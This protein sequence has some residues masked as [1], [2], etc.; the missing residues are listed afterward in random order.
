[1]QRLGRKVSPLG[2]TMDDWRIAGE[3]AVRLGD[4]FDLEFVDEVTDEIAKVAP[5]HL[6]A[7]APLLR[8]A[9][10][11]VVLPVRAHLDEI[12]L[13]TRELNIMSEDGQA[14]SWDPIR[15]EAAAP[16]GS[17]AAVE[18]SGAGG[19]VNITPDAGDP[20]DSPEEAAAALDDAH[21]VSATA[22]RDAPALHVWD[23]S[24]GSVDPPG[25]D[26]YALRL[27][28]QRT[29][30]DGGR[31]VASTP[32]LAGLR[33][34]PVLLVHAQDLARIGVEDGASV[35]VTSA[36]ATVT[37]PVRTDP[38]VPAGMARL[39]FTADGRGAAELID[40]TAMV[41]DLRVETIR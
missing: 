21:T 26:A 15:S 28:A 27:V 39:P 16:A 5:S 18:A 31:I 37:L 20:S 8:R 29:L 13:R 30:Y 40:T 2:T 35:R 7:R 17:T 14:V 34:E 6:G 23:R 33:K 3:L 41:T 9:R 1:V 24:A 10:D 32:A 19:N 4:D 38:S 25:R 12:L 11:G 22:D 36:R